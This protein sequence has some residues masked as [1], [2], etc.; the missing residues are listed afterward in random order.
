MDVFYGMLLPTSCPALHLEEL[1][2]CNVQK[3]APHR[4]LVILFFVDELVDDP[5]LD[6]VD[7]IL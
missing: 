2:C 3:M 4:R 5:V 6:A 7:I 1:I